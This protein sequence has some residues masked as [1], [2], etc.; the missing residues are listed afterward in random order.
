[1]SKYFLAFNK[2]G[3]QFL[4]DRNVDEC[5]FQQNPTNIIIIIMIDD[6]RSKVARGKRGGERERERG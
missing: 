3:D 4:V 2:A 5:F 1:M 6:G